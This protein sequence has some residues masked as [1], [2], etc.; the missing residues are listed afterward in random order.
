MLL[1]SKIHALPIIIEGKIIPKELNLAVKDLV[2]HETL[3]NK[4][5]LGIM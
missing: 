2:V 3:G 5:G 4:T 1:W